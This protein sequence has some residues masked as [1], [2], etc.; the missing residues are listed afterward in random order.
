MDVERGAANGSRRKVRT[1][2]KVIVS[3]LVLALEVCACVYLA[4][5]HFGSGGGGN[6]KQDAKINTTRFPCGEEV[7]LGDDLHVRICNQL[8]NIFKAF[9]STFG[10]ITLTADEWQD[11][12]F[13]LRR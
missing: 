12:D 4:V 6:A 5:H 7:Q 11:L 3:S 2:V 10:E 8:I 13:L 9:N 1:T